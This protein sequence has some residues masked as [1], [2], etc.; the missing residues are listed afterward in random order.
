M[1][2]FRTV[3]KTKYKITTEME[4]DMAV[5]F[6]LHITPG[7]KTGDHNH[8]LADLD[9]TA[10]LMDGHVRSLCVYD[11]FFYDG[12]PA[13]EVWTTLTFLATRF[14]NYE[15]V[16]FVLGQGYRNP[17][18]TALM[19]VTLQTLSQGRLTLGIG[20]GWKEDEFLAYDYE[21][22]RAGIRIEQLED[23]LNILQKMWIEEGPI[24]YEGKHYKITDAW[25]EPKPEPMVPIMVGGGGKKTM[26]LAAQYA[27]LWN[28]GGDIDS[29]TER[30]D[31]LKRHCNELERNISTLRLTYGGGVVIGNTEEEAKRRAEQDGH[32]G[33]FIG[34]VEQVAE[35]MAEF[36]EIGVNYFM[37]KIHG[38]PDPDIAGL[39][40]EELMPKIENL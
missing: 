11:H 35:K 17:A 32:N 40:T 22:P 19:A 34:T 14:Q 27:D 26:R 29:F 5:D 39:V 16:S 2:T 30:L 1:A 12:A 36:V 3:N 38:L 31:I 10:R 33:P 8:W 24:S 13:Y 4:L 7:A 20:A 6:G 25:C 37:V 15:I 23:T 18:L 21:F 28:T 9:A